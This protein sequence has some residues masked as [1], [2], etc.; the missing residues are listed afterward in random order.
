MKI[1]TGLFKKLD[2]LSPVSTGSENR[3]RVLLSRHVQRLEIPYID[4]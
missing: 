2:A 4:E 1:D 3:G